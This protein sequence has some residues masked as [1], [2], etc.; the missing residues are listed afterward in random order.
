MAGALTALPGCTPYVHGYAY[1]THQTFSTG[2]PPAAPQPVPTPT[3]TP[4]ADSSAST[5]PPVRS[6]LS[7]QLTY[8]LQGHRLPLVGAQVTD[9][10]AGDHKVILYGFVATAHGK[11][12]AEDKSRRFLNEPNAEIDNRIAIRPELLTPNRSVS[13]AASSFPA[14]PPPPAVTAPYAGGAP[15]ALPQQLQPAQ[16]NELLSALLLGMALVSTLP[17]AGASGAPAPAGSVA[18]PPAAPASAP[19]P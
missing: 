18:S 14:T 13:A 19:S 3:P 2:A 12:D 15:S 17:T 11:R 5:A 8:Y 7:D 10:P 4:R 16:I 6:V 9:A 1:T